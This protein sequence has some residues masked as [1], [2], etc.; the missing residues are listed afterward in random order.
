MEDL[1][2]RMLVDLL[3][4]RINPDRNLGQHFILDENIISEAVNMSNQIG[5]EV[6]KESHILEIG[7]GP[8]SLTL[9]LLRK[10]AKI[11]AFEIDEQAVL[12]LN[13]VF[14]VEDDNLS[15]IHAD[16]LTVDWPGDI[17]HII[18]NIPYGI[19][20]P[21]LERIQSHIRRNQL[22]SVVL[23]VQDEFSERM[24]MNRGPRS[25][26]PLGLSLWLDFVIHLGSKVPP[27]AFS[28]P[29]R[30]NSR[31]VML[32]PREEGPQVRD[33]K[34]FKIITHHCFANRRRKMRTL[35]SRPPKRISRIRGWHK[36]RWARLVLQFND[37]TPEGMR[38]DWLEMRPDD[39]LI[40]EWLSLCNH[41]SDFESEN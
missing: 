30:V 33:R 36:S 25:I 15:I 7:P 28:P 16:A 31:L 9:F 21:I 8:G 37:T 23:L 40:E 6:T 18:A 3:R 34:M 11:T 39:M 38:A 29:P 41:I 12:H 19:S 10:G 1:D 20:S 26:G 24:A 2:P 35:L 32:Q 27:G 22:K 13:R 4:D 14:D 17:T 5:K